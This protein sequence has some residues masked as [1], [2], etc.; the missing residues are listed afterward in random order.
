MTTVVAAYGYLSEDDDP[1]N[2]QPD[3]IAEA[4]GDLL[5]WMGHDSGRTTARPAE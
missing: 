2:W 5:S 4:P 3:G 1:R